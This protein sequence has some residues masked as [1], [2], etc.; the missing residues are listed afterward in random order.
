MTM[1]PWGDLIRNCTTC[2]CGPADGTVGIPTDVTAVLD[3][4]KN[5]APP[6]FPCHAVTKVRADLDWETP[7]QRIDISDVTFCL[8]AFRGFGYPPDAFADPQPPPWDPGGE[9]Y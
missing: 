1:S 5:L 7:N 2:P 4:F 6:T 9:C 8:D 3:K